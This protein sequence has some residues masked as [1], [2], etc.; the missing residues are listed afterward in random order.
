MIVNPNDCSVHDHRRFD[1]WENATAAE[2][3]VAYIDYV[4]QGA[5]LVGVTGDEPTR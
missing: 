1:T 3:L 5:L 4:R 2:D